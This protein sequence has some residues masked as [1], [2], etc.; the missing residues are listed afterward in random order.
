MYVCIICLCI[1]YVC[2]YVCKYIVIYV[3]MC[4]CRIHLCYVYI[5]KLRL[6]LLRVSRLTA[7]SLGNFYFFTNRGWKC[8]VCSTQEYT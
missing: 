8:V 4:V 3:C 6:Q 7:L 5:S 1:I 2:M